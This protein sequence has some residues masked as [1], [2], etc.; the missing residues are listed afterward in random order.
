M[1]QLVPD[2]ALRSTLERELPRLPLAYLERRVAAP[3]DWDRVPCSYLLLSE[4][5]GA[6]AEEARRRGWP[7]AEIHA[8]QHLDIVVDP[9]RV[10][11]ALI[12]LAGG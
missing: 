5:Y 7:M 1:R 12:R 9:V 2:Q 4:A 3:P 8:G 6:S 10:T 11:G